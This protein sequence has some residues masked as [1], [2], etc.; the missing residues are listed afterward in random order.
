MYVLLCIKVDELTHICDV[1]VGCNQSPL[2][3]PASHRLEHGEWRKWPGENFPGL[4]RKV[5]NL[6]LYPVYSHAWCFVWGYF[7]AHSLK[8]LSELKGAP[9]FTAIQNSRG[10]I[11]LSIPRSAEGLLRFA[12]MNKL[13]KTKHVSGKRWESMQTIVSHL[14]KTFGVNLPKTALGW[15]KLYFSPL[16][17]SHHSCIFF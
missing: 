15:A 9:R 4:Q 13:I 2:R 16:T 8:I 1:C 10:N 11:E 12:F 3:P 5:S 7:S 14:T 17:I 6:K